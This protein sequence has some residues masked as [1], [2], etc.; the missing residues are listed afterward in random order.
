MLKKIYVQNVAEGQEQLND[1]DVMDG[2]KKWLGCL[3]NS[4]PEGEHPSPWPSSDLP[5]WPRSASCSLAQAWSLQQNG[6]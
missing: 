3:D 2:R 4:I 1:D 6:L 5:G